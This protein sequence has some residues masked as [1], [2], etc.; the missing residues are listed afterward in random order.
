MSG[1]SNLAETIQGLSLHVNNRLRT[2]D[3]QLRYIVVFNNR[4]N[5]HNDAKI[6]NKRYRPNVQVLMNVLSVSLAWQN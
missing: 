6:S 5:A 3:T 1:Q 4:Y 2:S